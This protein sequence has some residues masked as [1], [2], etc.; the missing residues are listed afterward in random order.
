MEAAGV[1][2]QIWENEDEREDEALDEDSEC[3]RSGADG[4]QGVGSRYAVLL[5]IEPQKSKQY[6]TL[7]ISEVCFR[8]RGP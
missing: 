8:N 4:G 1:E 2:G 3:E 7:R 5:E 6:Q